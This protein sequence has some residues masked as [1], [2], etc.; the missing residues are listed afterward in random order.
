M[1]FAFLLQRQEHAAAALYLLGSVALSILALY[2]GL[3]L[4]RWL[5]T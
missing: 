5:V 3:W 4:V 2:L 1:D